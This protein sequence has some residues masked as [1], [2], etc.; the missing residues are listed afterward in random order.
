MVNFRQKISIVCRR[1]CLPILFTLALY[2]L[3][4]YFCGKGGGYVNAGLWIVL[5]YAEN[6]RFGDDIADFDKDIKDGKAVINLPFLYVFWGVTLGAII[7]LTVIFSM[8]WLL[9]PLP[10]IVTPPLLKNKKT[11]WIKPFFTPLIALT[12]TVSLWELN[13]IVW[14]LSAVLFFADVLL[15]YKRRK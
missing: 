7:T 9:L 6:I 4:Y 11:D 15:L 3:L 1:Y 2:S 10:F 14:L 5:F 12:V 13:L 8:W